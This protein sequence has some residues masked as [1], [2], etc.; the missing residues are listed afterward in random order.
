MASFQI[1]TFF[2]SGNMDLGNA[3]KQNKEKLHLIPQVVSSD[4]TFLDLTLLYFSCSS[5]A[6]KQPI[7]NI[8]VK[9]LCQL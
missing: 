7:E 5:P 1:H 3:H 6:L 2:T 4:M 8:P 9:M